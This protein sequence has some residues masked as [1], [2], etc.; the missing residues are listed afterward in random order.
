VQKFKKRSG[1]KGHSVEVNNSFSLLSFQVDANAIYVAY[2]AAAGNIDY[3][4]VVSD[5][6]VL[7][8]YVIK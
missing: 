7:A 6:R 5:I 4:Q 1:V 2:G 3:F 8:T